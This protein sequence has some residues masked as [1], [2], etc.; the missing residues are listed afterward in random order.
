M[1]DPGDGQAVVKRVVLFTRAILPPVVAMFVDDPTTS[2]VGSGDG[3]GKT[4]LPPPSRTK[5][6][7]PAGIVP[8]RLE[9]TQVGAANRFTG[10]YWTLQPPT[11]TGTDPRLNNSTK[12]FG[13]EAEVLPPPG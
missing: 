5:K 12:S 11:L 6:Y 13:Y 1:F 3:G 7:P 9:D 4:T 8:V 2:G 10:A